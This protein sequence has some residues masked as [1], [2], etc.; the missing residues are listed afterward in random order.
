MED[1]GI[2][3][4]EGGRRGFGVGDGLVGGQVRVR[5]WAE[6]N[7]PGRVQRVDGVDCAGDGQ[8]WR[9][10]GVGDWVLEGERGLDSAL[11]EAGEEHEKEPELCEQESRPDARLR[12]HVH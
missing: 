5:F 8:N 1:S 11:P 7:A 2:G 4:V 12:E 10:S 9:E 3:L 6:L